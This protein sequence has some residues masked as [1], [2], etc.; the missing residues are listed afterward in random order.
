MF[1]RR[2]RYQSK[3]KF[4][5]AQRRFHIFCIVIAIGVVALIVGLIF[6][7]RMESM[8]ITSVFVQDITYASEAHIKSIV[9]KELEGSYLFVIPRTSTIFFP[10]I[11]IARQLRKESPSFSNVELSRNGLQELEVEITEYEAFGTFCTT[12]VNNDAQDVDVI[13]EIS[14]ASGTRLLA[15]SN[16]II[17][18]TKPLS[19]ISEET[20]CFIFNENTY[21]YAT[22]SLAAAETPFF[23]EQKSDGEQVLGTTYFPAE[24]IVTVKEFV[25]LLP[26]INFQVESI[27]TK[28]GEVYTLETTDRVKI[29]IETQDNPRDMF[30]NLKTL[31]ENNVITEGYYKN[32]DYI[33]LR[34]GNRVFY[35]EAV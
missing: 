9:E 25:A 13:A 11:K 21:I 18:R 7:L 35:R 12:D 14:Y 31:L 10:K 4:L 34:F 15:G 30:E 16:S 17:S 22:T 19:E 27:W 6:L 20:E 24:D 33:D 23:S 1:M 29:H 2:K 3:K 26:E 28:D 8:Q 5:E 32:L